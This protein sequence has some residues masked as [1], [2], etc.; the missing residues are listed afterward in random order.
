M[1]AKRLVAAVAVSAIALSACAA[2]IGLEHVGYEDA[3]P[4]AGDLGDGGSEAS[5]A[6]TAD[7]EACTGTV[8]GSRCCTKGANCIDSGVCANDVVDVSGGGNGSCAV[9]ADGT[10]WCWGDD[11]LGQIGVGNGAGDAGDDTC[12]FI[13]GATSLPLACRFVATKVAALPSGMTRVGAGFQHACAI[14]GTNGAVWCWGHNANGAVGHDPAGDGKCP[15][16]L[17]VDSEGGVPTTPCSGV[18]SLVPGITGA[19]ELALNQATSCARTSMGEVFCWG[20]GGGGQ[21][22]NDGGSDSFAAVKVL[23]LPSGIVQIATALYAGGACAVASDGSA[24]CWGN[25]I[26][27]PEPATFTAHRV[28]AGRTTPLSDVAELRFGVANYCARLTDGAVICWGYD[29]N[30]QLGQGPCDAGGVSTPAPV[31]GIPTAVAL[32]GR[33]IHDCTLDADG[34]VRCWGVAQDGALGRGNLLGDGKCTTLASSGTATVVP[35]LPRITRI[36]T[37]IETTFAIDDSGRLWAWGANDTARIGHAPKSN[38]DLTNCGDPTNLS[39]C[40]P[41]PTLVEGLP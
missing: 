17:Q 13:N 23:G 32:D 3:S 40:N 21:L 41:S 28:M 20:S 6:G 36:A 31:V 38:K 29:D 34:K 11:S 24:W 8:C 1:S 39:V 15:D 22:G 10:V 26:P 33:W 9:V 30:A 25:T 18:P 12:T 19:V 4:E 37:G 27:P 16:I 35:G 2:V 5:D 7:A 14:Q